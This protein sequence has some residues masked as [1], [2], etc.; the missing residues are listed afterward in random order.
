MRLICPNCNAQYDVAD[1]VIPEGGR[2]VQCSS[3]TH[4]W[5]QTEKPTVA[6]RSFKPS[7]NK[8]APAAAPDSPPTRQPLDSSIS[9]ILREEA[10]RE[11]DVSP[12][13]E[14]PPAA[15]TQPKSNTD[16]ADETRRRIAQMTEESGNSRADIAAGATGAVDNARTVPSMDEINASLRA[17]A[18]ASDTSGLTEDEKHEATQRRG[19]RRGFF[20]VLVLIGVLITP[21]IF[22]PQIMETLPQSRDIM[23][24][25]VNT[26]DQMRQQLNDQFNAVRGMAD[27]ME[28]PAATD[29]PAAN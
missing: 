25:Y 15:A 28:A 5:F 10:A 12:T 3:C 21:Y 6:G 23:T 14:T 26:V 16:R 1:D 24:S 18:Q 19:F 29:G 8:A 11:H 13:P 27:D 9:D 20:F 17:R 2:D 7:A 4:T 22:A